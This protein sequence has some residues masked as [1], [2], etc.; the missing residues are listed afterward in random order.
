MR[1]LFIAEI[2]EIIRN[3]SESLVFE[4]LKGNT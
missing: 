1:D 3:T 2:P 4:Y